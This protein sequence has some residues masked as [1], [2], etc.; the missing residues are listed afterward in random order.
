MTQLQNIVQQMNH[1]QFFLVSFFGFSA[2]YFSFCTVTFFIF[3][4]HQKWH[5]VQNKEL[6][7]QQIKT[8]IKRSFISIFMF[9]LLGILLCEGLKQAF[10][11]WK[12][13]FNLNEFLIESIALFFWNEIYFYIMHRLFHLKPLYKYHI[14]HHYSSVPTPFSAYSFHWSEGII[15][16]A[17]MPVAMIFHNFQFYSIMTLPMMSIMM[18]VLGHSNIDFFPHSNQ[19]SF[20]SFSKRH[21][22]HHKI[23]HS[24]YGFF[25]PWF[26]QL[27]QTI[28]ND[29]VEIHK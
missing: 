7:S 13:E 8:E 11:I 24:N 21:S 26:D 29:H 2:L 12:Y 17:V 3:Q 10:F 9:S 19:A 27:F 14:D 25:L 28:A 23:P 15:L 18:N 16:G 4:N 6:R 22:L 20:L 5:R 1:W